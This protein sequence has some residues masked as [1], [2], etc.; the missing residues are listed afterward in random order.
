LRKILFI[1][2]GGIGNIVQ[3]LPAIQAISSEKCIVDLKLECNSSKDVNEIFK[4]PCVRQIVENPTEEYDYQLNG[5][6]TSGRRYRSKNYIKPNLNYAQ[7]VPEAKI[8]F[9]MAVQMGITAKL[10]D[11]KI[12]VPLSGYDP[13]KGSVAIYPGS[14]HNWAMKRW[15]K[16][17]ELAKHFKHV[18]IVGTKKDV[19]SHGDPTWIT[20][21]WK[22]P[23]NV[24][25]YHGSLSEQAYAISKCDKFIGNDG[26]LGHV[27]A[28]TGIPTFILFGPSSNIKNKPFTKHSYVIAI[29]LPCRPCQFNKGPDGKQI[30]DGGKSN[31]PLDMKCMREMSVDYVLKKIKEITK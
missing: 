4:L 26:G 8:Y 27:A 31:C 19:I 18:V 12:A 3:S 29:D 16:Y 9:S 10:P 7:H 30:F 25:F 22:W 11:A 5:P 1:C 14:K 6:F 15:D 13:P 28:A 24:E 17:D 23:E 2:G 21:P 20:D